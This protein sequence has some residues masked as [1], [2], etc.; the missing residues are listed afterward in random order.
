[1]KIVAVLMTIVFLVIL[2]ITLVL[3]KRVVIAVAVI[4]VRE[5]PKYTSFSSSV[6]AKEVNHKTCVHDFNE[7]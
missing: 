3:L 4:K 6:G 1:M 2:L 5:S 7:S